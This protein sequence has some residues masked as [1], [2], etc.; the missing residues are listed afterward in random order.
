MTLGVKITFIESDSNDN[1]HR[2][3]RDASYIIGLELS[4]FSSFLIFSK[5]SFILT[6]L[7]VL[8]QPDKV[9]RFVKSLANTSL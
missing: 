9:P 1:T 4:N 5:C 8:V 7:H 3:I 6:I 2:L